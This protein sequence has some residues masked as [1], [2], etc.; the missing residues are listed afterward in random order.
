MTRCQ[1]WYGFAL[2]VDGTEQC[3]AGLQSAS[4]RYERPA[5]LGELEISVTP[6]MRLDSDTVKQFDDLGVKRLIALTPQRTAEELMTFIKRTGDE[7]I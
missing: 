5:A 3:L 7:L 6:R 1:G 4:E 2:D